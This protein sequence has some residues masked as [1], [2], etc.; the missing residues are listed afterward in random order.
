MF[1]LPKDWLT[2]HQQ[3]AK[4]RNHFPSSAQEL[5]D[6]VERE[7]EESVKQAAKQEPVEGEL[8]LLSFQHVLEQKTY[9]K[10]LTTMDETYRD[11]SPNTDKKKRNVQPLLVYHS[12]QNV[13]KVNSILKYGYILPGQQHPT[14]GWTLRMSNGNAYGDGIYCTT[15]FNFTKW[16]SFVDFERSIQVIINILLPGKT[17]CDDEVHWGYLYG[18]DQSCLQNGLCL[19]VAKGMHIHTTKTKK[20]DPQTG[21]IRYEEHEY[22]TI[23]SKD[24]SVWVT[25]SS[26]RI[27]PIALVTLSPRRV[28]RM[29]KMIDLNQTRKA[30]S[31]YRLK[32]E[33]VLYRF[34]NSEYY[35]LGEGKSFEETVCTVGDDERSHP[36]KLFLWHTLLAEFL[37]RVDYARINMAATMLL[38]KSP[39][40]VLDLGADRLAQVIETLLFGSVEESGSLS[41]GEHVSKLAQSVERILTENE[42]SIKRVEGR[43]PTSMSPTGDSKSIR[44]NCGHVVRLSKALVKDYLGILNIN[45]KTL[46]SMEEAGHMSS[47]TMENLLSSWKTL[48]AERMT[49][50]VLRHYA[51]VSSQLM[52]N[53]SFAKSISNLL[54]SLDGGEKY[55]SLCSKNVKTEVLP[56]QTEDDVIRVHNLIPSNTSWT[57]DDLIG[58]M[59]QLLDT[60]TAENDNDRYVNIIYIFVWKP[61]D[62]DSIESFKTQWSMYASLKKINVKLIFLD[63]VINEILSLKSCIQTLYTFSHNYFFQTS[64]EEIDETLDIIADEVEHEGLASAAFHSTEVPFPMGIVGEGFFKDATA[65]PS[66]K[67]QHT[68]NELYKGSPP[69]F[70]K[71]DAQS[72]VSRVVDM[73]SADSL[74]AFCKCVFRLLAKFQG[75]IFR[76]PDASKIYGNQI[77]ELAK[78]VLLY[79][80]NVEATETTAPSILKGLRYRLSGF[81]TTMKT[82][83]GVS[84][85]G[86]WYTKLTK[87]RF[88]K[89]VA[90][91]VKEQ[92]ELTDFKHLNTIV[93]LRIK[94]PSD[95]LQFTGLQGRPI[96]VKTFGGSEVEPWLITVDCVSFDTNGDSK[97]MFLSREKGSKVRDSRERVI[98]DVFLNIFLTDDARENNIAK[99]YCGYV[100]TGN[101]YLYM[102]SQIPSLIVNCMTTCI[103]TA[104][105]LCLQHRRDN[106]TGP[107][108]FPRELV[109]EVEENL[110]IAL[111]FVPRILTIMRTA[112]ALALLG[113]LSSEIHPGMCFTHAAGIPSV[114][115]A[116]AILMLPDASHLPSSGEKWSKI[117]FS[118]LAESVMRNCRARVRLGKKSP[119]QLVDKALHIT[120]S[121]TK[122]NY[123]RN[124]KRSSQST[125]A[126]MAH[127]FSNCSPFKAVAVLHFIKVFHTADEHEKGPIYKQCARG[128][129][130]G[131]LSMASFLRDYLPGYGGY[132]TQLGLYLQG[133]DCF[134][135]KYRQNIRFEDPREIVNTIVDQRLRHYAMQRLKQQKTTDRVEK[136]RQIRLLEAEPYREYHKEIRLFTQVEIDEMNQSRAKDD[137]LQ[138]LP[139][140]MLVHHCC[141]PNCPDYLQNLQ[142]EKDKKMGKR[143]GLMK[144]L[145]H[146]RTIGMYDKGWQLNAHKFAK[147]SLEDFTWKM[148]EMYGSKGCTGLDDD[149][150]A[151]SY[152][153]HRALLQ[154]KLKMQSF[155]KK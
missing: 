89:Q 28:G 13:N 114:N 116:L 86:K 110:K 115:K 97:S 128:F 79:I 2:P 34:A 131:E 117:C 119:E 91:R 95:Y 55:L 137:Q 47:D 147:L 37:A 120:N 123:E 61:A 7:I 65:Q 108:V 154:K 8:E 118:L 107:N 132:I 77:Q 15:D 29:S 143:Y 153:N 88:G 150:L 10:L 4:W 140:G 9:E 1:A 64:L 130:T 49:P 121:A 68:G 73:T 138:V 14:Q 17:L 151:Q 152:E 69:E 112:D 78:C 139:H 92:F 67:I 16:Y 102:S 82:F 87:M 81:L 30:Y 71:Q 25:A 124:I 122:E 113:A 20:R 35:V 12:T 70:L 74:E 129:L 41:I 57:E 109:Q 134:K 54:L 60:V 46:E 5:C 149:T 80:E 27:I 94:E 93:P 85:D 145:R 6:R 84:F 11:L 127:S 23:R 32:G 106:P 44:D 45:P 146:V 58:P 133:M 19:D 72:F 142:T 38:E 148:K 36:F 22:H 144:H 52:A 62:L 125:N 135:S 3:H 83:G 103:E 31:Q 104:F 42:W 75:L 99:M 155:E 40:E 33:L 141:A 26:E 39:D 96:R 56:I 111:S 126:F 21:K 100:F 50:P 63:E 90:R 105:D 66:W 136:R 53:K 98:T 59:G 43:V 24:M 51:V 18:D 101:P 76:S 48:K